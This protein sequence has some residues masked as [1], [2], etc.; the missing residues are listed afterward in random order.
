MSVVDVGYASSVASHTMFISRWFAF[1]SLALP[2][3]CNPI[4][5][6]MG[7]S[8]RDDATQF[9]GITWN[10]YRI[11]MTADATLTKKR[12]ILIGGVN[13]VPIGSYAG[14]YIAKVGFRKLFLSDIVRDP[15][16]PTIIYPQ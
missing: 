6:R 15:L 13:T 9:S 4:L 12:H 5:L 14:Y 3:F 7:R 10:G 2:D 8:F 16:C 1:D 11:V